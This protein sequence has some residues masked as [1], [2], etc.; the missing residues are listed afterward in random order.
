MFRSGFPAI[1]CWASV[2]LPS[3]TVSLPRASVGGNASGAHLAGAPRPALPRDTTPEAPFTTITTDTGAFAPGHR[4]FS[5]YDV[6][7]F[8]LQAARRTD[9]LITKRTLAVQL[10]MDTVV[11]ADTAGLWAEVVRVARACGARFT[12]GTTPPWALGDL[13]ELA[14]YAQN[15]SLMRALLADRRFGQEARSRALEV[16]VRYEG[17]EEEADRLLAEADSLKTISVLNQ[18]NLHVVT[19]EKVKRNAYTHPT[20]WG[21]VLQQDSIIIRLGLSPKGRENAYA[22]SAVLHAYRS[23]MHVALL[24]DTTQVALVA[25]SAQRD[26]ALFPDVTMNLDFDPT[27]KRVDG[28][29]QWEWGGIIWHEEEHCMRSLRDVGFTKPLSVDTLIYKL[30]PWWYAHLRYDPRPLAPK[31]RADFWWPAPGGSAADTVVPV[32]GKLNLICDGGLVTKDPEMVRSFNSQWT[33]YRQAFYLKRW[34]REYGAAGLSITLVRPATG[35]PKVKSIFDNGNALPYGVVKDSAEEA[36]LWHWYDQGYHQ[37]PVREA[38]KVVH[39]TTWFPQ[40]DGRRQFLGEGKPNG[41]FDYIFR[42]V[43]YRPDLGREHW[44]KDDQSA[45][46]LVGWDGTILNTVGPDGDDDRSWDNWGEV[47][48]W[49]LDG[50]HERLLARVGKSG[51]QATSSLP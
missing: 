7:T 20:L 14:M 47:L 46:T 23:L 8:C 35:W 26:L 21:R 28:D 25:R 5:R 4:D 34:Q 33:G 6:P 2:L 51:A 24:Y 32:P 1:V 36:A 10:R 42:N 48:H 19:E 9:E 13:F 16:V 43:E 31:L 44:G 11:A 17:W 40:P 3:Q 49:L 39:T 41:Y 15:D 12:L 37:L 18:L 22:R 27:C 45:C 38:I 50:H 29:W 30:A